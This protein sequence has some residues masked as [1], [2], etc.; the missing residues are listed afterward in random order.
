MDD[1]DSIRRQRLDRDRVFR[2]AVDLADARG[3]TALTMRSLAA[4]LGVKPMSLYHHVANKE[5]I[6][7]GIVDAVF[8]EV[9]LPTLDAPWRQAIDSRLRSARQVLLRHP[10]AV[11]LM[12]SRTS[13]GPATL[14]QHEATLAVLRGAGF[15]VPATAHA[16]ALLDAYLYGSVLQ[17]SALPFD[18]ADSASEAAG[19]ML[20]AL[21]PGDYPYLTE[22]ATEHVLEP[23][24]D[25]GDEFGFGLELILD[26]LERLL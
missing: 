21:S 7:D 18:D 20:S 22:I 10:W 16:Y 5:A 19:S 11:P 15:S 4:S 12:E 3:V 26:G 25:F 2:A 14:R 1:D 17:E 23:G 9:S 6:L 8:A 24:Y 13:P